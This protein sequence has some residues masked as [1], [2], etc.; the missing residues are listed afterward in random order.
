MTYFCFCRFPLKNPTL[1]AKWVAAMRRD[2][3]HPGPNDLLCSEHFDSNCFRSYNLQVRLKEDA[4]PSIFNFPMH[5]RKQHR[6]PRR[7]IERKC[8]MDT[9]CGPSTSLVTSSGAS[10]S[11]GISTCTLNEHNYILNL[12]PRGIKRKYDAMLAAT[13]KR[14]TEMV[15]RLHGV[16]RKLLRRQKKLNNMKDII[17]QLKSRKDMSEEAVTVIEQCFGSL[18]AELLRRKLTVKKNEPYSDLIRSFA[19]TLH[20]YSAKAY[21]FVRSSFRQALPHPATLRKWCTSVDGRPGFTAEAF[22]VCVNVIFI[23]G[24]RDL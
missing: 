10:S 17:T 14:C 15:N 19:M 8:Q 16:R 23:F 1:L 13:N 22:E 20:F 2:K 24:N 4:V 5:L 3:W 6:A 11:S 7:V 12:S 18:P 21:N 9:S